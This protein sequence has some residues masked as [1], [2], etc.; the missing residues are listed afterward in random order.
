M[1]L[2]TRQ[3]VREEFARTGGSIS[4]WATK[5]R[6]SPPLVIAIL[7]DDDK[8]PTRK[9]LRGHSHDIAVML[10]IKDGEVSPERQSA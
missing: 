9:C 10:R 7:N 8:N 6:F 1:T 4:A 5:N 2:K 3:Q